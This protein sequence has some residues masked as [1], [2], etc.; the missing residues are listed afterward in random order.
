MTELIDA[1]AR[2]LR[3]SATIVARSTTSD[4]TRATPCAGWDLADLLGHM[5]GQNHGFADA[6]DGG[7]DVAAFADRTVGGDP[8]G[9]F[10]ASVD[11]VIDAFGAPNLLDRNVFMAII[12]GG[13]ELPGTSVV[14]FHLV[15]Y[16]V[17][18]WDVA[19]T[20][21]VDATY[22]EDV[23]RIAL[24]VAESLPDTVRSEDDRTPFR[25]TVATSSADLLDQLVANLGR[26]PRW[27]P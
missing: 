14:G 21:G 20:L 11:R 18:G 9:E 17:H 10:A 27:T 22:D 23:V 13:I 7:A 16:V 4:L 5:I 24:A 8:V 2:A 19:M 6:V 25:P 15:D 12:R 3:A 1:H 26:D